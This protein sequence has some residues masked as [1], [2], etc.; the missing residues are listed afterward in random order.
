[1]SRLRGMTSTRL[2]LCKVWTCCHSFCEFICASFLLHLEFNVS[3]VSALPTISGLPNLLDIVVLFFFDSS[4]IWR[5]ST[6]LPNKYMGAYP[7]LGMPWPQ[8]NLFLV[9]FFFSCKLSCLSFAPGFYLSLFYLPLLFTP[10]LL[11]ICVAGPWCLLLLLFLA[12]QSFFPIF[13]LLCFFL[14]S[15]LVQ[16]LTIQLFVRPTGTLDGQSNTAHRG[17]QMH[18][19]RM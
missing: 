4:I 1:M 19:E 5:P 6:Q 17:K 2:N 14:P 15:S 18:H 8:L 11:C 3:L 9:S 10:Y 16:L 13:M 12:P 7:F